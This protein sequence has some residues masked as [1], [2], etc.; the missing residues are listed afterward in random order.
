MLAIPDALENKI[1]S[2]ES[3]RKK[4]A[5]IFE[6][7]K[8][9]S[10]N[11]QRAQQQVAMAIQIAGENSQEEIDVMQDET[12]SQASIVESEKDVK[13]IQELQKNQ[14]LNIRNPYNP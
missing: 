5:S 11:V 10:S 3:Y 12:F 14:D 4:E 1:A 6:K 8:V 13:I 9:N 7:E 2:N